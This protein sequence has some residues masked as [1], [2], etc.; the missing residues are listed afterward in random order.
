MCTAIVSVAP[1]QI[2]LAGIRDELTG[3][4]WRPPD[5]HWPQ[6]PG[7]TGGLDLLA[8]GT[9]LAVAPGAS[10]AACVL[11]GRGQM[12]PAAT[13]RSRGALPLLAAAEGKLAR[14]GL[15]AFDPFHLLTAEPGRASLASWDGERL[16]ERELPAGLHMVVNSGLASDLLAAAAPGGGQQPAGREHEL[17]RIEHFL[18]RLQATAPPQPRPGVPVAEAWG[19]WLPLL[20]GDGLATGDPRALIVRRDLGDGRVYGSTSVSLVALSATAVRYDFTGRPGDPGA[21]QPVPLDPP[22]AR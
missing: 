21:W 5:R 17:A 12:A 11:N 2:L 20:N 16:T 14:D 18:P 7:L 6:Y 15:A 19:G 13:R 3:R 22:G 9:W 8:G 4:D 1:G 10:R